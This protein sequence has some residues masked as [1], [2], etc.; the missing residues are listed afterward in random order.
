MMI[1][2][3]WHSLT[4]DFTLISNTYKHGCWWGLSECI[5]KNNSIVCMSIS[6]CMYVR[7]SRATFCKRLYLLSICQEKKKSSR[8]WSTKVLTIYIAICRFVCICARILSTQVR[9]FACLCINTF[10]WGLGMDAEP[11][12]LQCC[13][14]C[15][16]DNSSPCYGHYV[17]AD[18]NGLS[19]F[20][21]LSHSHSHMEYKIIARFL[22]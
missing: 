10:S 6:V 13:T 3:T 1:V 17:M 7:S 2:N 5:G 8:C 4:Y 14:I 15:L 12:Q 22:C 21:A 20:L 19:L 9:V 18:S 11:V 16:H